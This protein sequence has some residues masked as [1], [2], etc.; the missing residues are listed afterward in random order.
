MKYRVDFDTMHFV[1]LPTISQIEEHEK[2][3]RNSYPEF[4]PFEVEAKNINE[5]RKK[6]STVLGKDLAFELKGELNLYCGTTNKNSI[7]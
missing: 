2:I 4:K 7:Y 1:K 3:M 6:V 5:A